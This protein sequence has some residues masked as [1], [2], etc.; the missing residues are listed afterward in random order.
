M[1]EVNKM[2]IKLPIK[3]Y[4]Y[5]VFYVTTSNKGMIQ[6]TTDFPINQYNHLEKLVNETLPEQ[7][8]IHCVLTSI[9]FLRSYYI[10]KEHSIKLNI[11][12]KLIE[13][14]IRLKRLK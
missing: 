14:L 7:R 3:Q 5:V 2:K 11:I 13:G 8:S 4:E 10:L 12:D 6:I 9:L 1:N